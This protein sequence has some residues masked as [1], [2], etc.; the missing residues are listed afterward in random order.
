MHRDALLGSCSTTCFILINPR[1][2]GRYRA[3]HGVYIP[4]PKMEINILDLGGRGILA[5]TLDACELERI[6]N[7]RRV[8]L[9]CCIFSGRGAESLMTNKLYRAA[10]INLRCSISV[11]L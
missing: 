2:R 3:F 5:V 11:T 9:N 6:L 7:S 8:A 1:S 10:N 4:P